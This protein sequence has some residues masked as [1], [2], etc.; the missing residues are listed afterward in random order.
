MYKEIQ[1]KKKIK[2]NSKRKKK[3]KPGLLNLDC[4]EKIINLTLGG[5]L[6]SLSQGHSNRSIIELECLLSL[7]LHLS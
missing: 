6:L 5:H 3:N 2:T 4:V 1:N 7:N